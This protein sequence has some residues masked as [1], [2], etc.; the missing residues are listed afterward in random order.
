MFGI[1]KY[2]VHFSIAAK[3]I[4]VSREY[5]H[6]LKRRSFK[7]WY[8]QDDSGAFFKTFDAYS[9]K[10]NKIKFM[11]KKIAVKVT[12]SIMTL[13]IWCQYADGD[14]TK[15]SHA[16]CH[17]FIVMLDDLMFKVLKNS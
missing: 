10:I 4:P 11:Y 13:W 2:L 8:Y 3:P 12:S 16:E 17:V 9:E 15:G 7:L 14:C 6:N 5:Q 1:D